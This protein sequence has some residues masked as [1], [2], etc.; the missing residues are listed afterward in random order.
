MVLTD[1]ISINKTYFWTIFSELRAVE[2]YENRKKKFFFYFRRKNSKS[3][4]S[5]EVLF[6]IPKKS[7]HFGGRNF[8]LCGLVWQLRVLKVGHLASKLATRRQNWPKMAQNFVDFRPIK[9]TCQTSGTRACQTR[10]WG[11]GSRWAG[12]QQC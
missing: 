5:A 11:R 7:S 12:S 1:S 4:F 10:A 6:C 2:I 3:D 8:S 9:L